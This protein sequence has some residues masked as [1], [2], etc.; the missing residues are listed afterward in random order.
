MPDYIYLLEN[1]LSADQQNALRQLREA[2]REAGTLLFLTGDAVRD[3]TSG[4]AVREIEVSVQANALKLKKPI[5]K[6]G[7]Q[8][9]G[10]DEASHTLYLCFPGTVRVDLISTHHRDYPKPGRP[11]YHFS[12]IQ[13]DLRRRDFTA[14][15]MAISL[16]E[17]SYGLLMDPLNGAADIEARTL[18]LVSNYGFLEEPS[19]MI[20]AIRYKARLGWELD[21]RTQQRYENAKAENIIESLSEHDKSFELEQIGHEDDGLRVLRALEAEGWM[22]VLCPAWT[23]SKADEEKLNALHDLRVQLQ[24]QGVHPD[25]SA[26]Q[27]QLLTAKMAPKDLASLKKQLLRPGFVE[28][29]NSLDSLAAGFA[30]VLLNKANST[31]SVTYKLFTTHDPEAVLWLGFTSKDSA[32][33]AKY[34]LFL[35]TWPEVRQRIPYAQMQE[36]RITP[37]L[38]NYNEILHQIFLQ[39]IDGHLN[40]PE[41]TKAFLEPYSPPAPPPQITIKRSRAKRAEKVKEKSFDEQEEESEESGDDEEDL[42]DIGGGDDDD[43]PLDL[44]IPKS[45]LEE[46][47]D[48]EESDEE[49]ESEDEDEEEKPAPKRGKQAAKPEPKPAKHAPEKAPAAKAAPAAK[50]KPEPAKPEKKTPPAAPAKKAAPAPAA[51]HAPPVKHAAK[52]KAKTPAK[53]AQVKAHASKPAHKSVP[54]KKPAAPAKAK[55]HPPAKHAAKK[56]P[57]KPAK[58]R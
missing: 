30:K 29:W 10:E 8:V 43:E 39:L 31:P 28:E 12:S 41:E 54:S 57:A 24:M 32:V 15:A 22:K 53:A 34:E 58:K 47:I 21:P 1:R 18:R 44:K 38:A 46:E 3:L 42:D 13:E 25:M 55:P 45:D 40:T 11:A 23:S 35:K 19:L 56:A 20:R 33:K 37:E 27:M 2:A 36:M 5:E 14:N 48:E 16:N 6:L 9:W 52:P 17:G 51:K 26:A 7:A 4:H 49:E 50:S